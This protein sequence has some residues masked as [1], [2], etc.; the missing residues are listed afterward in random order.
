MG[1][2]TDITTLSI[3]EQQQKNMHCKDVYTSGG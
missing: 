2:T 1:S 3:L